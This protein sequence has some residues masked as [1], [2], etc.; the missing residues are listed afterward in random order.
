LSRASWV[1][2]P[3]GQ[4][5]GGSSLSIARQGRSPGEPYRPGLSTAWDRSAMGPPRSCRREVQ[6]LHAQ[7]NPPPRPP[8]IA[9]P[10]P[11]L[12]LRVRRPAPRPFFRGN[13]RRL[14]WAP[15][16]TTAEA[17]GFTADRRGGRRS[18]PPGARFVRVVRYA[19]ASGQSGLVSNRPPPSWAPGFHIGESTRD[20]RDREPDRLPADISDNARHG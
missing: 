6:F 2:L 11:T 13:T 5:V 3:V 1:R 14:G 9:Q 16:R 17:Q 20:S 10:V 4:R 15:G 18:G 7:G 12:A 8:N 19:P